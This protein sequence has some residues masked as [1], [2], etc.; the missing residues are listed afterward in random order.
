[1]TDNQIHILRHT[2]G[3]DSKKPGYRNRYCGESKDADL[4]ELVEKGFMIGP[5]HEGSVGQDCGLFYA[6]DKTLKLFGIKKES[7][8]GK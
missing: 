3:A 7:G 8:D 1:M 4:V 6:T 2:V 5:F